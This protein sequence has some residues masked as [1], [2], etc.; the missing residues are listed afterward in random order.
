MRLL[1]AAVRAG[2]QSQVPVHGAA[3][4]HGAARRPRPGVTASTGCVGN[5]VYTDLGDDEL[6]V[7]DSRAGIS[8]SSPAEADTIASANAALAD[9]HRGRR[10]ALSTE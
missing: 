4:V 9:Y 6:Y 5:R 1:E 3:D 10:Q 2:V 8:P 7:G